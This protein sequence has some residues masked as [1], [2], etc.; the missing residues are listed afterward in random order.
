M[1]YS[2]DNYAMVQ[3]VYNYGADEDD[4]YSDLKSAMDNLKASLPSDCND[5]TIMQISADA[6]STMTLSVSADS[7]VDLASLLDDEVVPDIQSIN[8]IAQVKVTGTQDDYFRV[9]LDEEKM[10]QYGL[11]ISSI[12]SAIGAADFEIPLGTVTMGSQDLSL[13]SEGTLSVDAQMRQFPLQTPSGQLVRLGDV[14]QFLRRDK[15]EAGSISR[16][17][18]RESVLLSVTKQDSAAAVSV[19][20][21]V[22]D[23]LDG[24]AECTRSAPRNP[25]AWRG[26]RQCRRK[27]PPA[28]RAADRHRAE[29]HRLRYE[30]PHRHG[31]DFG[32]R[33]DRG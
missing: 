18:G 20:G 10:Q 4:I 32:H 17:N 11:N 12:A 26:S 9:V 16:Y 19:C 25:Q 7:G 14:A 6:L 1:T 8:G 22:I 3:L 31:P 30:R 27:S 21:K 15:K 28:F 33:H 23:T 5:P 24:Y 29:L 2:Y 13:G